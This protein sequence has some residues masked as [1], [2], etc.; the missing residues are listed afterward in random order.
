MAKAGEELFRLVDL[1]SVWVIADVSEQDIALIKIGASAKLRFRAYPGEIFDGKV[2][3]LLHELETATRTAK[4]RIEV[5]NPDHRLKHEMFAEVEIDAGAGVAPVLSVPASAVIDSGTRQVVLVDKGGGRF[6][7]RPVRLGS[8]GE[9]YIEIREGL[10][11]GELVVVAAT[12]LIDAESNLKAALQAFTV[13][14]P[15]EVVKP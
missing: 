13:P 11:D 14:P 9:G 4:V 1:S 10:K 8:R 7:P 6:E 12:F 15:R 5:A 2:T 3:F